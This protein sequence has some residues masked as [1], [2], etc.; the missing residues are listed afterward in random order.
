MVGGAP[1]PDGVAEEELYKQYLVNYLEKN[2]AAELADLVFILPR[3]LNTSGT[4]SDLDVAVRSLR[5]KGNKNLAIMSDAIHGL[6][7]LPQMWTLGLWGT[8]FISTEKINAQAEAGLDSLN[9][10]L[11][12]YPDRRHGLGSLLK[13]VPLVGLAMAN[14]LPGRPGT[15]IA[16]SLTWRERGSSRP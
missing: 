12:N 16:E 13:S 4:L 11:T 15:V 2:Q 9:Q 1:T 10:S 14:F 3:Y 6:Y 8:K 5:H 7:A